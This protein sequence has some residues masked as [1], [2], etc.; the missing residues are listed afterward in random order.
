[1]KSCRLNESKKNNNNV[2]AQYNSRVQL[3]SYNIQYIFIIYI[4]FSIRIQTNSAHFKY[5]AVTH[6]GELLPICT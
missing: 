5:C 2:T 3:I 6:F 4:Y 1:M